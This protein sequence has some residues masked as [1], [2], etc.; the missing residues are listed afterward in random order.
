MWEGAV[1]RSHSIYIAAICSALIAQAASC[2]PAAPIDKSVVEQLERLLSGGNKGEVFGDSKIATL[3]ET[4]YSLEYCTKRN[5]EQRSK[6]ILAYQSGRTSPDMK[7]RIIATIIK[8]T[9]PSGT[10]WQTAWYEYTIYLQKVV[11]IMPYE[12]YWPPSNSTTIDTKCTS[13]YSG[14]AGTYT[15]N[16]NSTTN[17]TTTV[18]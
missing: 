18:R 15:Y 8:N 9:G 2:D 14:N 3:C 6:F 5:I 16:G 12:P 17:C 13:T 10:D 4:S 11:G 1:N 7:K